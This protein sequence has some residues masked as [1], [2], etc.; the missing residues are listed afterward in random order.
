MK[1]KTYAAIGERIGIPLPDW[2]ERRV[3]RSGIRKFLMLAYHEIPQNRDD[4]PSWLRLWAQITWVRNTARYDLHITIPP[5]LWDE[6]KARLA[7]KITY[8]HDDE[9]Y[10]DEKA[11]ALRWASR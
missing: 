7:A 8:A 1:Y 9:R 11:K 10:R 2:R 4:D 5:K 6:D 3:T